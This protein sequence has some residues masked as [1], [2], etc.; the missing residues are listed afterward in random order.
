MDQSDILEDI[1]EDIPEGILGIH[2]ALLQELLDLFI[3]V[4]H[5]AVAA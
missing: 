5:I 4:L 3:L 1:L 2:M